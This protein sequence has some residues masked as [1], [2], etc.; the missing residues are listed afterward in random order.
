MKKQAVIC[1]SGGMDSSICLGLA[2]EKYGAENI[3]SIGFDYGQRHDIELATAA[4]I[5]K[6]WGVDR[7]VLPVLCL[8]KIT[9]NSLTNHGLVVEEGENPNTL[10][11]GRNG[12]MA[13][14]CAIHAQELGAHELYLGVMEL[15]AQHCGYRDCSRDYFDLKEKILRIDLDDPK[16]T[17]TTPLVYLTKAQS[18][19]VAEKLGVL[20]YL[21]ETT[22]S[23]YN[24]IRG[25]G[26]KACPACHLRNKGI[27]EY[28]AQS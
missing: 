8:A 24:G 11:M 4:Q 3:L 7:V 26:C 18:L 9:T 1:H 12:L 27:E 14:L 25:E 23:C 15:E 17:I 2:R 21:L 6:D 22:V 19:A 13:R 16:F 28:R 5:C 10:V 20:E